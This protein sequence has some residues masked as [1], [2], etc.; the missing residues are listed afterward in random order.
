[1]SAAKVR[2]D[3]MLYSSS[4][5][6]GTDFYAAGLNKEVEIAV[7]ASDYSG[8]NKK[9]ISDAGLYDPGAAIEEF[10]KN[11]LEKR[12][13]KDG[14]IGLL[15]KQTNV[16]AHEP[17]IYN[18]LI[19][20]MDAEMYKLNNAK[21]KKFVLRSFA[22][23]DTHSI[24]QKDGADDYIDVERILGPPRDAGVYEDVW[25]Q[26]RD[27]NNYWDR[28]FV[29]RYN[30]SG[31][32]Q[33][34]FYLAHVV[35]RRQATHANYSFDIEGIDTRLLLI[36]AVTWKYG[37]PATVDNVQWDNP[38]L[39][40]T[41]IT[42]YVSVNRLQQQFAA[43]LE[44]MASL[45]FQ[46][47]WS[48]LEGCYWSHAVKKVVIS[49]FCPTRA[50][51][52]SN[53][54][55]E[56]YVPSSLPHEMIMDYCKHPTSYMMMGAVMNYAEWLGVYAMVRAE[57]KAIMTTKNCYVSTTENLQVLRTPV[58]K[59]AAAS[60]VFGQEVTSVM[61]ESA[62]VYID[63]SPMYYADIIQPTK[64][65][66][67]LKHDIGDVAKDVFAPVSGALLLGMVS[68]QMD[69]LSHLTP[70]Q[71][72]KITQDPDLYDDRQVMRVSNM[73]RLF[74]HDVVLSRFD[75]GEM[76][77]PWANSRECVLEVASTV[78]LK[79][80]GKYYRMEEAEPRPGRSDNA[81][82]LHA[83]CVAK[84]PTLLIMKPAFRVTEWQKKEQP[85][86]ASLERP[87]KR[88]ELKFMVR[89]TYSYEPQVFMARQVA[90]KQE[91]FVQAEATVA[92]VAP[93]ADTSRMHASDVPPEAMSA[94]AANLN[95]P[96]ATLEQD[97]L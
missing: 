74:G 95:I 96:G 16:D 64:I 27:K 5:K 71:N 70:V 76:I 67:P 51:I 56:P 1:M 10:A 24:W 88:A 82:H 2:V 32:G 48:S 23:K 94:P 59:A 43:C 92:P 19:S 90:E 50:R 28:P 3:Q 49:R 4:L 44:L 61:N 73:Y 33:E 34:E 78:F 65:L 72:L 26:R 42:D 89:S 38:D 15:E 79:Y 31:A 57:A 55:G 40:W 22:Y 37:I 53:L 52:K 36:D 80:K 7:G 6:L 35:G 91:S 63:P 30:T 46:P 86:I 58:G 11:A 39:L 20:W 21:D 14:T 81:P 18:M 8:I 25:W 54:E 62:A 69:E 9:F 68:E 84:D 47:G 60:I 29:L 85:V 77:K 97:E 87:E 12:M 17:F 75:N 66:E 41:Y 13:V 45:A 93:A 83:L